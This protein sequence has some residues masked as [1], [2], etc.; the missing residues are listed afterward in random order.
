MLRAVELDP[1]FSQAWNALAGM[2]V[3][4]VW[5]GEKTVVEAWT[6]AAPF[7]AKALAINPDLP[8]VHITLGRFKR[9]F[10]NLDG[11]IEPFEKALELDPGNERA[12]EMLAQIRGINPDQR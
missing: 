3:Y 2:E 8:S 9:E 10:G 11:A 7:I 12:L 1:A 5:N 6:I 4:P